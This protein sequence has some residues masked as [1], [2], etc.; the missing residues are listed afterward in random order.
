MDR[1]YNKTYT[2]KANSYYCND[3]SKDLLISQ[4][5]REINDIKSNNNDNNYFKSKQMKIELQLKSLGHEKAEVETDGKKDTD[6]L[7]KKIA[8]IK[9][10]IQNENDILNSLDNEFPNLLDDVQRIEKV[11]FDKNEALDGLVTEITNV[12][13]TKKNIEDDRVKLEKYL[14]D[15]NL[16]SKDLEYKLIK[17]NKKLD[18]LVYQ[19]EAQQE[20]I[21]KLQQELEKETENE[22]R[23]EQFLLSLNSEIEE[24][25][26]N[27][28][29]LNDKYNEMMNNLSIFKRE[30]TDLSA[31]KDLIKH[32]HYNTSNINSKLQSELSKLAKDKDFMN[33]KLSETV[34]KGGNLKHEISIIENNCDTKDKQNLNLKADIENMKNMINKIYN[35]NIEV[36]KEINAVSHFD[37]Q[38]IN[39]IDEKIGNKESLRVEESMLNSSI[40]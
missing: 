33:K 38:V 6:Y 29:E 1:Y 22:E 27:Y 3:N 14:Y 4:L 31:K 12:I 10:E 37:D 11:L 20:K 28:E 7:L 24:S 23:L 34:Q 9:T 36:I 16:D 30:I 40:F 19:K 18:E 39:L 25:R 2:N 13:D 17:S 35:E 5:K 21:N 8:N 26:D 32:E 15:L